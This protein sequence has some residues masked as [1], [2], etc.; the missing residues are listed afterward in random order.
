MTV[1]AMKTIFSQ[2]Q[3]SV[4]RIS[5]DREHSGTHPQ[6]T[7]QQNRCRRRGRAHAVPRMKTACWATGCDLRVSRVLAVVRFLLQQPLPL[8]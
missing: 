4:D 3:L 8:N 5:A 1:T 6:W 2:H 7:T